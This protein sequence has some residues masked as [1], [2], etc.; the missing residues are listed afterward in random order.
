[1]E[2]FETYY[3]Q[4]QLDTLAARRAAY[5]DEQIAAIEQ[6]WSALIARANDAMAQ[7]IDPTSEPVLAIAREWA[8]LV[9]AFTGGD[10]AIGQAVER[11]WQEDTTIPDHDT[12]GVRTLIEWLGPAMAAVAPE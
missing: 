4:E 3:T 9:H 8:E 1:M 5:G 10:P 2:H 7:G 12:A 6:Q 11:M